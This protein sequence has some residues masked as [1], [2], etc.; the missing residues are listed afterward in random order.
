M[1]KERMIDIACTVGVFAFA[2]LFGLVGVGVVLAAWGICRL[3]AG[4]RSEYAPPS[5]L[6]GADLERESK[7]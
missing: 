7:S 3:I 4:H 5:Q 2:A 1:S 6:S